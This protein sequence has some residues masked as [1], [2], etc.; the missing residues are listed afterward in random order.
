ME[1]AAAAR[2]QQGEVYRP[3]NYKGSQLMAK[4]WI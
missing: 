2:V 1:Q 3:N 4:V